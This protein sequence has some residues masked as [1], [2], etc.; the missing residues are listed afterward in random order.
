MEY[1]V[2]FLIEICVCGV[3]FFEL[4]ILEELQAREQD[5]KVHQQHM[6]SR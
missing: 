6:L 2:K 1:Q 5:L 3:I 4:K